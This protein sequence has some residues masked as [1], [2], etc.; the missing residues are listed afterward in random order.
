MV[1]LFAIFVVI[2]GSILPSDSR[3][4]RALDSLQISDKI[5]HLA[6]YAG[7]AFLPA[8]HERRRFVIAAAIGSVA[9]GVALEY[10]Q[11]YSGWRNFEVADMVAD[12]VGV[13]VGLVTG[14]ATRWGIAARPLLRD[15]R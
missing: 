2:V 3:A 14:V 12:G 9:L 5:E 6:A 1:W 10:V 4:M 13:C 11:L 15:R 8:L 7:L